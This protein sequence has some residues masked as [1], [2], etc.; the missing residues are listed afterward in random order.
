MFLT[1]TQLRK[2]S[3]SNLYF[4]IDVHCLFY[5]EGFCSYDHFE[6][7]F[8]LFDQGKLK[9]SYAYRAIGLPDS[10]TQLLK[11]KIVVFI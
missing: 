9:A 10:P 6:D 11:K 3:I 2:Q 7:L 1:F 4:S 5:H 8:G